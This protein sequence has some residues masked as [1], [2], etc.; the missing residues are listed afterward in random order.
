[1][2]FAIKSMLSGG[3]FAIFLIIGNAAQVGTKDVD[4]GGEWLSWSPAER[5]EYVD[6]FISGYLQ[7]SNSACNVADDLFSDSK[8]S[9]RLGDENHPSDMPSARCLAKM[10]S[11]S[12][13]K[14]HEGFGPD[15]TAYTNV[16]TEFYSKHSEYRGIA[17]INLIKLLSDGNHKTADELYQMALKGELHPLR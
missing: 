14:F 9:Y 12:K 10:E 5:A 6:G 11:Y 8:A 2:A 7:G 1:M 16:I 4:R 3:V 17:F 15:F 13:A